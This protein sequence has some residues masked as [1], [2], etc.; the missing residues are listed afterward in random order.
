MRATPAND[1]VLAV[2]RA[3][4]EAVQ[5][6]DDRAY[7]RLIDRY[8]NEIGAC[9]WRFARDRPAHEELV[10]DVFVE[11]YFSLGKFR[12]EAPLLHWL[13]KIATRVGYG[14]WKRLAKER[15]RGEVALDGHAQALGTEDGP[16]DPGWAAE[17]LHGLLGRL[18]PRDR[19]V[20]TLL[21]FEELSVAEAAERTGWSHSMVKVQAFRARK[22][23]GRLLEAHDWRA[24]YG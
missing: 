8:Q 2:D 1:P 13:R 11:A 10:H 19:L 5:E 17:W 24:H 23:L 16:V 9:M 4:I 21:Y 14:Y 18:R 20:L 3:D 15:A 22:K 6:G 7:A 12:G